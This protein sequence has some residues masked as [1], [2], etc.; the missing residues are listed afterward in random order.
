MSRRTSRVL[1]AVCLLIALPLAADDE[2]LAK[3]ERLL[4]EGRPVAALS[5]VETV[6]R[7]DPD[8]AEALLLRSTARFLEGDMEA[9]RADLAR[10]L[11][12]DPT[13]R[14]AWLNRAGLDIAEERYDA[15]LEALERAR[16]LDPAASDND[17]NVGAVL[18]LQGRIEEATGHFE[19]YLAAA[20]SS[21]G[22]R[23][24]AHYL[25]AKNYAGQGYARV[26]VTTL[27][28]AVE[29]DEAYR[30]AARTDSSFQAIAAA[31]DFRR[32]LETDLHPP[33]PDD[34][35]VRERYPAA[36]DGG[37][38]PLLS[39]VLEALR[40]TGEPFDPRVEVTPE[41]ALVHGELRV[42]VADAPAAEAETG[43]GL[44]QISAR[45]AAVPA[46]EWQR[47]I[48]RVLQE[49]DLA[50]LRRQRSARPVPEAPLPPGR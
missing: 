49:L 41:W 33:A 31:P 25:V 42:K 32:L 5:E 12:A 20:G 9:G 1:V 36:Y 39:A 47:R 7:R 21:P 2:R 37:E 35:V 14:Q 13:L 26:A 34:R 45:P 4:D 24:E 8:H 3:A 44:L 23:G 27:R 17:L 40:L 6:L 10:A 43:P 16:E 30:L 15:A 28:R 38:G 48:D 19:S 22:E 11:A 18:L 50:L 46:A 29:E